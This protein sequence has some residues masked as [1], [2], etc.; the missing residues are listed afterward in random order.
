MLGATT[1]NPSFRLQAALLSRMRVFVLTKLSASDTQ[2]VLRRAVERAATM[3][4]E[5]SW[6]KGEALQALIEWI[7]VMADG[8]AR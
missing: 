1:E 4:Y 2:E 3:D 6:L 5:V 7:A 8:D